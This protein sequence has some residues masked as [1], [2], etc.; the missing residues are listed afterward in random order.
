M[1]FPEEWSRIMTEPTRQEVDN[2]SGKWSDFNCVWIA[3][4]KFKA[5]SNALRGPVYPEDVP[6]EPDPTDY[7]NDLKSP[8]ET[9]LCGDCEDCDD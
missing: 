3:Q 9:E 8:R 6:N 1:K 4:Q 7:Y 5:M 2:P